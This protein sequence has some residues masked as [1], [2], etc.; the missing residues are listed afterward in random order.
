MIDFYAEEAIKVLVK[1]NQFTEL[2]A[3]QF[4]VKNIF[5]KQNLG[6]K[7]MVKVLKILKRALSLLSQKTK[8]RLVLKKLVIQLAMV[9]KKTF[10]IANITMSG[11]NLLIKKIYS[12][13]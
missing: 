7:K 2:E 13:I 5:M 11:H 9:R 3:K 4:T 12:N 10:H 1:V 6:L 8:F